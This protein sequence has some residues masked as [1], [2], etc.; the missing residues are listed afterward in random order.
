MNTKLSEGYEFEYSTLIE[1]HTDKYASNWISIA[2][3]SDC[4]ERRDYVMLTEQTVLDMAR[5]IMAIREM[6]AA[7]KEIPC[8]VH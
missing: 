3:E 6:K 8:V 4:D 1:H 2:Q 5:K 7:G